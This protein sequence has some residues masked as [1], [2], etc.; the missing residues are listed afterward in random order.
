M[1][2]LIALLCVLILALSAAAAYAEAIPGLEDGVLTV[3]MECA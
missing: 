1:K 2:K 3:A